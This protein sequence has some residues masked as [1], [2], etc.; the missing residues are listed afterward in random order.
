MGTALTRDQVLALAPDAASAKAGA[1]LCSDSKWPLLGADAD[2]VWGECKGSGAKPYQTQVE[3]AAL[4]SKCSCPSRKFPCKHGLALLLLYAQGHPRF[5][6]AERPDWAT[7]WLESRRD[8]AAKKEQVAEKKAADPAASAAT[9]ARR[10]AARWQRIEAGCSELQRWIADQFRR[11]LAQFGRDQQRDG[12]AMAAR[13][14]DAQAPGLGPRLADA[15]QALEAGRHELA[16]ERLG[17][18]QLINLAVARRDQLTPERQADL[19]V[20]LGWALDRDAVLAGGEPLSDRWT[21][22]GQCAEPRDDRLVERRIWLYGHASRRFALLQDF[23]YG[24]QGWD[25]VWL[26]GMSYRAD[27]MFHPGSV[28]LR[29]QVVS[30]SD[31]ADGIWPESTVAEAIDRASG[32]L[33]LNPW[34]LSVPMLIDRCTPHRAPAGWQATTDAGAFELQLHDEAGW[35]LLASSGGHPMRMLGEWDGLALRPV[36]THVLVHRAAGRAA[37]P[38]GEAA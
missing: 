23:A 18:L 12:Q 11:G 4:V 16:I 36:A 30:Q 28:R 19:R 33:A 8:R 9:A 35:A 13:M 5:S 29:A 15:L 2:A 24:G 22:L 21:V 20:T 38:V 14:V 3:L 37:R 7:Q 32:W 6:N 27:V 1:G 34:L 10:E 31:P 26:D 25:G 17:V